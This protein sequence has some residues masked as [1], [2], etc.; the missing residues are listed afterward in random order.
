[1]H[2]SNFPT[3]LLSPSGQVLSQVSSSSAYYGL[4]GYTGFSVGSEQ[5]SG[6]A[7]FLSISFRYCPSDGILLHT[8]DSTEQLYFSLGVFNLQL[9][10]QFDSGA[11]LRE[12]S[13]YK[14]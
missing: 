3:V 13:S 5:L 6:A 9:L 10:A 2:R 1:M 7:D 4:S 14:S 12:V 8:T 11:G